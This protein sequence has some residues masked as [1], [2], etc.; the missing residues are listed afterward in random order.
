M[1][2][3]K[4]ATYCH[5]RNNGMLCTSNELPT[6]K[7]AITVLDVLKEKRCGHRKGQG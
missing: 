1:F 4:G 7:E 3:H 2:G 6:E 5:G